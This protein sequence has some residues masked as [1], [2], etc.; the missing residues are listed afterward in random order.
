MA[1]QPSK[2][3]WWLPIP[4]VGGTGGS[5]SFPSPTSQPSAPRRSPRT[6]KGKTVPMLPPDTKIGPNQPRGT[7]RSAAIAA[8]VDE[9]NEEQSVESE[10][11]PRKVDTSV[12]RCVRFQSPESRPKQRRRVGNDLK[13]TEAAPDE[14]WVAEGEERCKPC[15]L[16]GREVC[17]PQWSARGSCKSCIF[18]TGQSWRC[19][20]PGSWL[21]K[22]ATLHPKQRR[23]KTHK[24]P[25][26]CAS[27]Q[28]TPRSTSLLIQ[29]SES[30]CVSRVSFSTILV[31]PRSP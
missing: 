7:K 16:V 29:S 30:T 23:A 31:P 5:P 8:H 26:L 27:G 25:F 9:A 12:R 28:M 15:K 2:S 20:P 4:S 3:Q 13:T 14:L 18:C 17:K 22:V 24:D 19:N 1:E 21:E 11:G 10:P 6:T